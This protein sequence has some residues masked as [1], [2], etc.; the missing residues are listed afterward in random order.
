MI[1]NKQRKVQNFPGGNSKQE[2]HVHMHILYTYVCLPNI[3]QLLLQTYALT[4][5]LT[6]LASVSNLGI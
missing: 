2:A 5:K 3:S 1:G 6:F 4:Q